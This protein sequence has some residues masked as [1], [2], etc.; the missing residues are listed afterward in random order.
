MTHGSFG[1]G[2]HGWLFFEGSQVDRAKG[3]PFRDLGP[4]RVL[5]DTYP[6]GRP[7]LVLKREGKPKP[8]WGSVP[9]VNIPIP[10]K[11]GSKMGGEF[12]HTNQN[13]IQ[14]GFDKPFVERW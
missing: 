7:C 8:I 2:M 1:H 11:I 14:N 6:F 3:T 4:V 9:P 13:G 12:T 10:T 5:F